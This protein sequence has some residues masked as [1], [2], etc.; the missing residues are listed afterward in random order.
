MA[1]FAAI[2][3]STSFSLSLFSLPSIQQTHWVRI[4]VVS[5]LRCP[6]K[7][8]P[9]IFLFFP[10]LTFFEG[11]KNFLR[12]STEKSRRWSC[13]PLACLPACLL[14]GFYYSLHLFAAVFF[15]FIYKIDLREKSSEKELRPARH[16]SASF[17]FSNRSPC[18]TLYSLRLFFSRLVFWIWYGGNRALNWWEKWVVSVCGCSVC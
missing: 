14:V 18:L 8:S 5:P 3:Q 16:R 10:P 2:K 11:R 6:K 1:V 9:G 7:V 4:T 17:I 13:R 12:L 15:F